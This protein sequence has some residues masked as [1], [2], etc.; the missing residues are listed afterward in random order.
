MLLMLD[1]SCI[2]AFG[3]F[4]KKFTELS[5]GRNPHNFLL[6]NLISLFKVCGVGRC[7]FYETTLL[8]T[9]LLGV[10]WSDWQ[11][12]LDVYNLLIW[13][14]FEQALQRLQFF[15]MLFNW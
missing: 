13:R 12:L 4:V 14:H 11:R 6:L 5:E 2:D 15:A 1:C 3:P 9:G 8:C 7:R 10:L